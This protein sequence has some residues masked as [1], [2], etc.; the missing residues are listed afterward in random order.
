[1]RSVLTAAAT[2][3]VALGAL[4]MAIASPRIGGPEEP[5]AALA[6]S[7]GA[8]AIT[9]SRDGQALFSTGPM[10]PG[11]SVAGDVRI[12]NDGESAGRFSVRFADLADAPGPYGGKLSERLHFALFDVT[13]TPVTLFSGAAAELAELD[14]GT[15]AAGERRDYR[16][17]ATFPD[18]GVPASATTGDNA[19]QGSALTLDVEWDAVASGAGGGSAGGGDGG[20]SGGGDGS[21]GG[22]D[23]STGGGTGGGAIPP[24]ELEVLGREIRVAGEALGLP[25]ATRCVSRSTLKLRIRAPKGLRMKR[26][27]IK[28]N[29]KTRHVIKRVKT[30]TL[31]RLPAGRFVVVVKVRAS[32]SR[33]F[34]AKRVYKSCSKKNVRKVHK[35]SKLKRR[36]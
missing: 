13:T 4:G 32:N 1:M 19:Y 8:L 25:S 36:R 20:S 11:G 29:G 16:V 21:T 9:N 23:G 6:S 18:G 10:R 27:V 15:L 22:G 7:T 31:R 35:K 33:V 26:A 28:V 34:K 30:V 12:G 14:L 24:D 17:V 2:L 3:V 5:R